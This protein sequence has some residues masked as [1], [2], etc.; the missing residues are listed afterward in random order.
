MLS[1][2]EQLD[3]VTSENT[4]YEIEVGRRENYL[5]LTV[6]GKKTLEAR[7][8]E[9]LPDGQIGML[10]TSDEDAGIL[11]ADLSIEDIR[12]SDSAK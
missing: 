8:A 4:W 10:F 5:W 12:D 9:P 7:D 2:V 1:L 6:N 3:T 11:L